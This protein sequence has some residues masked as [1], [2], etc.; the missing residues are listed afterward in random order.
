MTMLPLITCWTEIAKDWKR[1]RCWPMNILLLLRFNFCSQCQREYRLLES[2]HPWLQSLS[3]FEIM[4]LE[5]FILLQMDTVTK[6]YSYIGYYPNPGNETLWPRLST[7][8]K[9]LLLVTQAVP[10]RL[11]VIKLTLFHFLLSQ[12]A[13][14]IVKQNE[15]QDEVEVIKV[16]LLLA[17]EL[18]SSQLIGQIGISEIYT[19]DS[20]KLRSLILNIGKNYY[21][22]IMNNSKRMYNQNLGK[23]KGY[24]NRYSSKVTLGESLNQ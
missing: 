19:C 17:D 18:I 11:D 14:Y 1:N 4:G 6:S 5:A 23:A 21:V 15:K 3:S 20:R 10:S 12:V 2:T 9:G 22:I 8:R 13:S 16:R 7:F 24:V